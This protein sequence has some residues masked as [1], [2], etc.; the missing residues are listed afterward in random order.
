MHSQDDIFAKHLITLPAFR[1][2]LRSIEARMVMQ[3]DFQEPILDFGCGDG[4]FG[5]MSLNRD[6]T[7]GIDASIS[8]LREADSIQCY[9]SLVQ[10]DDKGL[11]FDAGTFNSALCNSV[12][13]HIPNIESALSELRRVLKPECML[14][15]TVPS[16]YFRA[17]LS[18]RLVLIKCGLHR[19][20]RYYEKFFDI[21][22]RHYHYYTPAEW[23]ILLDNAGIGEVSGA[24]RYVAGGG[25]SGVWA[26]QASSGGPGQGGLG[27]GGGYGST[28]SG[29]TPPN[30][31]GANMGA[32][33]SGSA[34]QG[35][36]D[37]STQVTGGS[38]V[39]IIRY[40]V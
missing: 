9:R 14:V 3:F 10:A 5:C 36:V 28:N 24:S 37:W 13:E 31:C 7:I 38:G 40:A 17:F 16:K 2:L 19:L 35:T 21:I 12:L 22:S 11:P 15:F 34:G 27:N 18:I 32:G 23:K 4:H 1:A 20:A 33:G 29:V 39:V 8:S 30:A 25:G 26:N 6:S